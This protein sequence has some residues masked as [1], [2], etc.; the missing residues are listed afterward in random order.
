MLSAHRSRSDRSGS[1]SYAD[2]IDDDDDK[3]RSGS[4]LTASAE[5][6]SR[7]N[8]AGK[9]VSKNVMQTKYLPNSRMMGI[10]DCDP[11]DRDPVYP[12]FWSGSPSKKCCKKR[13][14]ADGEPAWDCGDK[15]EEAMTFQCSEIDRG[16]CGTIVGM[17][18]IV[19]KSIIAHDPG[20]A[21]TPNNTAINRRLECVYD[22][23][24]VIT[25]PDAAAWYVQH[26]RDAK[27]DQ[28]FFDDTFMR[29]L[30]SQ[31]APDPSRCPSQTYTGG[32]D[33]GPV[34]CSNMIS[35]SICKAWAKSPGGKQPADQIM[36]EWC[37]A[38]TD[39]AHPLDGTRSDP[40]CRCLKRALDEN[41]GKLQSINMVDSGCWFRP[42]V[43]H[44][45]DA[46]LVPSDIREH[47]CPTS[48]CTQFNE[49]VGNDRVDVSDLKEYM[50]CPIP[51]PTPPPS[52]A[53]PPSPNGV[54]TWWESLDTTKKIAIVGGGSGAVLIVAIGLFFLVRSIKKT[55]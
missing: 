45:M 12:M 22:L 16:A 15:A 54:S 4:Y 7:A 40:A 35:S 32:V 17:E 2:I 11:C 37:D 41:W 9:V 28:N 51:G 49:I 52:P 31:K 18:R 23:G 6:R 38:H 50:Y 1:Y 3:R 30:C 34:V 5:R 21:A 33:K 27:K 53:P 39:P 24:E 47:A 44:E 48:V 29:D 8:W 43:D 19:P 14:S 36:H 20:T 25:D 13:I 46:H 10:N 55:S 42:C 26:Q